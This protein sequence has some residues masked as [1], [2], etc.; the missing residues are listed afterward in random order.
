VDY[1]LRAFC[2]KRVVT[3][4]RKGIA[5]A[6]WLM[7]DKNIDVLLLRATDLVHFDG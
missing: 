2:D 3:I 4:L 5:E 6:C 1:V 7:K